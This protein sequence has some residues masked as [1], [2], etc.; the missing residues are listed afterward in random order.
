MTYRSGSRNFWGGGLLLPATPS[1]FPT[2]DKPQPNLQEWIQEFLLGEGE[3][4]G[5]G[6][7]AP[8]F[9]SEITTVTFL[10]KLLLLETLSLSP[11]T[12]KS[13]PNSPPSVFFA[14]LPWTWI[15]L[16]KDTPLE[17][18][19]LV[20]GYKCCTDIVN[21]NV[22]VN[23]QMHECKS[24][25]PLFRHP[26]SKIGLDS[27]QARERKLSGGRTYWERTP[28]YIASMAFHLRSGF[29]QVFQLVLS[30]SR[31]TLL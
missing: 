6:E 11:K 18:P 21:I 1:L 5:E 10:C 15:L 7:V 27:S 3:G 31:T 4:E 2:T 17:H 28:N 13:Q 14:L 9:D 25:Q 19:F 24:W 26:I 22:K 16:V 8:N 12:N 23:V 20:L 30:W 29:A